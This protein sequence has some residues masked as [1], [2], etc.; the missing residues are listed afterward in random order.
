MKPHVKLAHVQRFTLAFHLAC[1][2]ATNALLGSCLLQANRLSNASPHSTILAR[3]RS[4]T[5][6]IT[7]ANLTQ[8]VHQIRSHH[9]TSSG[10]GLAPRLRRATCLRPR[11]R[12]V[13]STFSRPPL[14]L[15]TTTNHVRS[16][17][18]STQPDPSSLSAVCGA[19][20]A[21]AVL[22]HLCQNCPG[23][24]L[25]TALSEFETRCGEAGVEI[26]TYCPPLPSPG[27]Q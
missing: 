22:K 7:H 20:N 1:I 12:Q 10:A 2:L 23:E 17:L 19:T 4:Q 26:G 11:G 5:H 24:D 3:D 6:R 8:H 15:K 9:R 21:T 14:A 18:S 25:E 16:R 13:H 27:P